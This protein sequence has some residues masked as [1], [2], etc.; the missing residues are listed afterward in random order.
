MCSSES[1]VSHSKLG[2]FDVWKC[3]SV[4]TLESRDSV[5]SRVSS[6]CASMCF[7]VVLES[8]MSIDLVAAHA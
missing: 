1:Q 3:G 2:R 5:E 7:S 6:S 8:S 4:D